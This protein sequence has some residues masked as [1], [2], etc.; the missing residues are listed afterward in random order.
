MRNL[1]DLRHLAPL[2][3]SARNEDSETFVRRAW[4][5]LG[6]HLRFDG[7]S[8]ITSFAD[9]ESYVDV[10][11]HG[12]A[13]FSAL[14]ASYEPVRHLHGMGPQL[15]AQVGRSMVFAANDP[16][17]LLESRRALREHLL[18]FGLEF[19]VA[20][21]ISGDRSEWVTVIILHRASPEAAFT[22]NERE[23]LEGLGPLLAELLAQNRMLNLFGDPRTGVAALAAAVVD[24]EGKFVQTTPAFV[25]AYWGNSPPT[26]PYLPSTALSALR[27]GEIWLTKNGAQAL[28]AHPDVSRNLLLRLRAT[29]SADRLSARE[30][31]IARLFA[32]GQSYVAIARRLKVAPSTVR[33]HIANCYQKLNVSNRVS[34]R[35]ALNLTKFD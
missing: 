13:D 20:L 6:H 35:D 26:T 21:A 25:R 17:N 24:S 31:E 15:M 7:G 22:P 19:N 18:R 8:V 10:R 9:R 16:E 5:W 27:S 29:C 14:M 4:E 12:I 28:E 30:R 3:A 1:L 33:N 32:D 2:L 11:T 34:L 23:V